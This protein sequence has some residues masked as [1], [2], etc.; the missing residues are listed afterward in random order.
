MIE[1]QFSDLL[2]HPKEVT[3]E[4][5]EGDVL[6]HR[7]DAPDLRLTRADREAQRVEAFSALAR[8]FRNLAV[9]KPGELA[10]VLADAFAWL[11][12]LPEPDRRLFVSEFARLL[13]AAAEVDTYAPLGQLVREWRATAEVYADPTLARRLGQ[14]IAA[15]GEAIPAP[16]N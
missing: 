3:G 12:F 8:A 1:R 13:T 6:L 4:L 11:E 9:H 10:E 14:P 16:E 7:R 2:R 15:A 5:E